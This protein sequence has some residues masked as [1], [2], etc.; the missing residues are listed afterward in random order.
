MAV[1]QWSNDLSVNIA[2]I[3]RQHQKL[4]AMINDLSDAIR[5]ILK[6]ALEEG[7]IISTRSLTG[8]LKYKI[9]ASNWQSRIKLS[10]WDCDM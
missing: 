1:I 2:E 7:H 5:H 6:A 4:V 10:A 8:E 3:D 9:L